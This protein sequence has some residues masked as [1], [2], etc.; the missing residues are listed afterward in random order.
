M[1]L[2]QRRCPVD[3][4]EL[5]HGTMHTDIYTYVVLR[6]FTPLSF[7]SVSELTSDDSELLRDS[8]AL[9]ACELKE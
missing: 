3:Y 7:S 9:A 8:V 1:R 4:N 6:L 5:M 2:M